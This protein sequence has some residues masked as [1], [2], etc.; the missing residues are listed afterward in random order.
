MSGEAMSEEL[1]DEALSELERLSV[2]AERPPW[3]A[4]IEG[5]DHVSGDSFI[6]VGDGED[7]RED[8]YVSRDGG[9]AGVAE[10]DLIAGAR[11]ALPL[12]IGEVRRLRA[13]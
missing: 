11:N 5:R 4:M 6:Q 3:R 13:E 7:R 9:P 2:G 10:L 8:M 12:L 1:T